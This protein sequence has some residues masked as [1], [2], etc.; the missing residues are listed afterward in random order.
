NILLQ[1][2]DSQPR[3]FGIPK[4]SDFGLAKVL[5]AESLAAQTQTGEVLG[6]PY[7]MAP[8]QAAGKTHSIGPAADIY[9][10]GAILYEMLT[11]RPPFKGETVLDTLEQ[12]RSQAPVSPSR[13]QHRLP[14]DLGTICL[15][16]LAKEPS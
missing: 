11:G 6:T 8:E 9:A 1:T 10:L 7:Y 13:L 14:R 12:V 16:A 15:K 3:G 5:N 2:Q 4:V